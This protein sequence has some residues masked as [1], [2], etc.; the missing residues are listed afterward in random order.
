[1]IQV[2]IFFC[3]GLGQDALRSEFQKEINT[4]FKDNSDKFE[5]ISSTPT[6]AAVDGYTK[7]TMT[8]MYR[9]YS[10]PYEKFGSE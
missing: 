3:S 6:M 1:M 9:E 5:I 10:I 4:W 7:Y 8:I 2:K